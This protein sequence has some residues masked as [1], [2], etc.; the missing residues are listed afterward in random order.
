M[1]SIGDRKMEEGGRLPCT[2]LWERDWHSEGLVHSKNLYETSG[3]Y[4][5]R[6]IAE[7]YNTSKQVLLLQLGS[8]FSTKHTKTLDGKNTSY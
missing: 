4:P 7:L 5:E 2:N 8:G 3:G 6:R 1:Y